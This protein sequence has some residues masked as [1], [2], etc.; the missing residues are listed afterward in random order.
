[1][2]PA[3]QMQLSGAL[4][5]NNESAEA[6]LAAPRPIVP[7]SPSLSPPPASRKVTRYLGWVPCILTSSGWPKVSSSTCRESRLQTGAAEKL[8]VGLKLRGSGGGPR[9]GEEWKTTDMKVERRRPGCW[10]RRVL[11]FSWSGL[12]RISEGCSPPPQASRGP[13][14]HHA[15]AEGVGVHSQPPGLHVLLRQVGQ[16]A[17]HRPSPGHTTALAGVGPPN[18]LRRA[19]GR[20]PQ[21]GH[22]SPHPEGR[23]NLGTEAVASAWP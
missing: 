4:P 17:T 13:A 19:V 12:L 10:G 9:G 2:S 7:P 1:M 21:F 15:K 8:H 20:S 14:A 11:G 16:G 6:G 3:R 5:T 23:W 22:Q 18:W